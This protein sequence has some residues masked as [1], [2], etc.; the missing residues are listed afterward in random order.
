MTAEELAFAAERLMEEG[1]RDVTLRPLQMKKGRPATLMTVMCADEEAEKERFVRLI[2][3]YTTTIGIREL[4]SERFILDRKEEILDTAYGK[5]RCKRVSGYGVERSKLEYEDLARIARECGI[6]IAEAR[7]LVL[8]SQKF[9]FTYPMWFVPA[10]FFCEIVMALPYWIFNESR[11]RDVI[12]GAVTLILNI[13][14]VAL[15]KKGFRFG[16]SDVIVKAAFFAFFYHAG[17]CYRK[18]F[19]ERIKIDRLLLFVIIAAVRLFLA[20]LNGDVGRYV[21][22]NDIFTECRFS[23]MPVLISIAGIA[24]W[25]NITKIIAPV[26]SNS[27]FIMEAGRNTYAIMA[28][29]IFMGKMILLFME[30]VKYVS[31]CRLFSSLDLDLL[32]YERDY[33][34][35]PVHQSSVFLISLLA[36]WMSMLAVSLRRKLF[37]RIIRKR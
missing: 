20:M 11:L 25:L 31:S 13:L 29:H 18:Y 19:E 16:T 27:R 21:I 2:F 3:K 23:F 24:F 35:S 22:A 6:S 10:L 17:L 7:E 37:I 15:C 4:I 26:L 12:I 32:L 14:V 1:A 33:F 5:V 34:Y 8:G 30:A 28:D 36:I 9:A